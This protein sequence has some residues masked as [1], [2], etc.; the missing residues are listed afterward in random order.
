MKEALELLRILT[1]RYPPSGNMRHGLTIDEAGRLEFTFMHE[2]AYRS[3][4]FE[5]DDL[6]RSGA[7]KC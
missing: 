7:E 6:E 5:L 2:G 1:E 4:T 3:W